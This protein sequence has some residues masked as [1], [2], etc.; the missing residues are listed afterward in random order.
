MEG[1]SFYKL[2]G[3]LEW[4]SGNIGY[5]HIHHLKA[6]IP[7]Y[8]LQKCYN[9][10]P[11]VQNVTPI[12]LRSSFRSLWMHLYDEVAGRMVSFKGANI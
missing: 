8:N 6:G 7:N 5:H 10:V 1:A 12:T 11:A 3:L 9:A 4:F 2:P